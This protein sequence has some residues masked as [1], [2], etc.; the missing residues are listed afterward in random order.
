MPSMLDS[1]RF[2]EAW[3]LSSRRSEPAAR[4]RSSRA[5]PARDKVIA[6]RA[7]WANLWD[8]K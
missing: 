6:V 2:S 8:A 3:P 1:V 4:W 5:P 7:D